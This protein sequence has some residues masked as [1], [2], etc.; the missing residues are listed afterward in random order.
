[1]RMAWSNKL[2]L[3][4]ISDSLSRTRFEKI[5]QFF[6]FND[7]SKQPEKGHPN[8]NKL[9]KLQPLLSVLKKKFNALPQ[10]EHQSVDE[11]IIAF[12]GRSG[13]K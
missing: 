4:P 1:M 6:H 2:K 9:Y 8:Y 12:K 11:S 10:E 5:K 3:S 7:Y 13:L